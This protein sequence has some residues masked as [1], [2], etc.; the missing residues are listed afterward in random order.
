MNYQKIF[1]RA[2]KIT[3][4]YKI[5]WIFGILAGCSTSSSGGNFNNG[6]HWNTS[7]NPSQISPVLLHSLDP[8]LSTIAHPLLWG[9]FFLFILVLIALKLSLGTI[10]H[11]GIILGTQKAENDEASLSFGEILSESLSYFWRYLGASLLAAAPFILL[12]GL[13]F[14]GA[15]FAAFSFDSIERILPS[16]EGAPFYSLFFLFIG[17]ILFLGIAEIAIRFFMK[18]AYNALVLDDMEIIP[19]F[20][21]GWDIFRVYFLDLLL[22]AVI[23]GVIRVVVGFLVA[24]PIIGITLAS[25]FPV[26]FAYIAGAHDENL[27][28]L[29]FLGIGCII[30]Y[31]P[32]L[33]LL[34]G[35]LLTYT[36]SSWALAYL[37]ITAPE[38]E[39]LPSPDENA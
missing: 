38:E 18:I 3:W 28:G 7:A 13:M 36:E 27:L 10:G 11:I 33:W 34:T 14:G 23:L 22:F 9:A 15:L 16:L 39:A 29:L 20:R 35:I 8:F 30:A 32:I 1:T 17:V 12:Y 31:L 6:T 5:L 21:R 37:H 19:A 24:L 2:W 25:I 26:G 4:K